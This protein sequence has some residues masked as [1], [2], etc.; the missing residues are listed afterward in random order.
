MK[1]PSG[2]IV[3]VEY[4]DRSGEVVAFITSKTAR[5]YYFLYDGDGKRM[6][7]DKDP[8]ELVRRFGIRDKM[9]CTK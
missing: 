6:G 2:E 4:L 1:Y 9:E 3:W 8:S 7:R 5:D